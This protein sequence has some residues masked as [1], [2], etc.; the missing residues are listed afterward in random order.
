MGVGGRAG[1]GGEV[2]DQGLQVVVVGVGFEAESV[3]Q[4]DGEGIDE[5]EGGEFGEEIR[6]S[7]LGARVMAFF[8]VDPD[9]TSQVP[10]GLDELGPILAAFD[11]TFVSTG[12]TEGNAKTDDETQDGKQQ[13]GYDKRVPELR[14]ARYDG[15][16]DGNE[17]KRDN[18]PGC[19]AP[20]HAEEVRHFAM[21]FNIEGFGDEFVDGAGVTPGE[22]PETLV[23]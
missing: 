15:G 12:S 10:R 19:D 7:V 1:E 2:R 20:F 9:M 5:V 6:L 13:A 21:A 4:C 8:R 17:E 11:V 23:W 3:F 16:P 18:H 14:Y 22:G